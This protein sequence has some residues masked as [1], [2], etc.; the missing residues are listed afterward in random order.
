MLFEKTTLYSETL[1]LLFQCDYFFITTIHFEFT[2]YK[3]FMRLQKSI[4]GFYNKFQHGRCNQNF[5]T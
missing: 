4:L 2:L 3:V 1:L 5:D